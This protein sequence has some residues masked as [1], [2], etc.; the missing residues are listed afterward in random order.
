MTNGYPDTTE[1]RKAGM[2]SFRA[3]ML[4]THERL[5]NDPKLSEQDRAYQR[6][7]VETIKAAQKRLGEVA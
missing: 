3:T 1:K 4:K 5:A 6:D 7:L 2:A